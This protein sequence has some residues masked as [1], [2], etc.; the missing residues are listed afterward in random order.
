MMNSL[1]LSKDNFY[2]SPDFLAIPWALLKFSKDFFYISPDFMA[3]PWALKEQ[4]N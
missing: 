2:I 1:K 4:A 3:I